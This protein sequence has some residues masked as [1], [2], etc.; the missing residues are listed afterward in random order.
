MTLTAKMG[1][2]A[3]DRQCG[4]S[5]FTFISGDGDSNESCPRE[6]VRIRIYIWILHDG[7]VDGGDDQG[8]RRRERSMETARI[9]GTRRSRR[10]PAAT[11]VPIV[12]WPLPPSLPPTAA[13]PRI[14]SYHHPSLFPCPTVTSRRKKQRASPGSAA[15]SEMKS[16][17]A[18]RLCP[19]LRRRQRAPSGFCLCPQ[20]RGPRPPF[21]RPNSRR[22]LRSSVHLR[23]GVVIRLL[24]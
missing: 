15:Q 21:N 24:K 7:D 18:R 11:Q 8:G 5:A 19:L 14:I 12:V 4:L 1:E 2:R 17:L 16:G 9:D 13:A 20:I 3:T 22:D 6:S 23:C 10:P